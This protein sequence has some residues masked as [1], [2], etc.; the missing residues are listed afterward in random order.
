MGAIG[1]E[2]IRRT[3]ERI[4]ALEREIDWMRSRGGFHQNIEDAERDLARE[5]SALAEQMKLEGNDS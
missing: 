4:I 1:R 3:R 5:R 2:I